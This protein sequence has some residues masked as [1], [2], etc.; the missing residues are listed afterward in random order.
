MSHT[1]GDDAGWAHVIGADTLVG[2]V[3]KFARMNYPELYTAFWPWDG[4]KTGSRVYAIGRGMS[5]STTL[6]IAKCQQAHNP[7][8]PSVSKGSAEENIATK[9]ACRISP[10]YLI[11]S[12]EIE[13]GIMSYR[14]NSKSRSTGKKPSGS[15]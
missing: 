6:V 8:D 10:K 14:V 7:S 12:T 1:P 13:D 11:N 15:S 9:S 2:D 3:E 4:F 5:T